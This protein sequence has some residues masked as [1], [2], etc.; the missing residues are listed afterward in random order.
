[1]C[2]VDY[3]LY[4]VTDR[5]LMRTKTLEACVEQALDGGVTMVQLR[6]KKLDRDAFIMLSKRIKYLCDAYNVPLVIND[7]LEVALGV[8]SMGVH[9]GQHDLSVSE[10]RAILGPNRLLGV[11]VNTVAQAERA[12][13]D[14]ADY[15]GVGAMF[16]T[17]T[18]QDASYVSLQTLAAIREAVNLPIVTI[19]G[20]NK[21]TIPLC[22][23]YGVQ[24]FA[25][26]S[27]LV[28]QPD[29]FLAAKELKQCSEACVHPIPL[30]IQGT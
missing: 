22:A 7:R 9:I 29:V 3:A 5:T 12:Q 16:G 15:L 19:G 10:T 8:G 21:E 25:V 30:A 18:K 20:M 28:N 14:G 2:K 4:M 17:Q 11:S 6:E 26:V 13:A 1:M 27:A 23:P 24:G